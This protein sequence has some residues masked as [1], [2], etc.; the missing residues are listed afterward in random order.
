MK[1]QILSHLPLSNKADLEDLVFF[2]PQQSSARDA[3]EDALELYGSPQI[4]SDATGLRLTLTARRDAQCLFGMAP[5][6]GGL[7]LAGMLVYLRTGEDEL[8]VVHVAVA[9]RYARSQNGTLRVAMALLESVRA[10]ARALRGVKRVNVLYLHGRRF[11][12]REDSVFSTGRVALNP[13]PTK[14]E[15]HV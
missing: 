13:V 4:V 9:G 8:L 15:F 6:R 2:N 7:V 12:V 11:R 10:S 14:V 5:R 1:L 3:I